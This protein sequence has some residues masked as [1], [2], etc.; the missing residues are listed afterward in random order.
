MVRHTCEAEN[1]PVVAHDDA[2]AVA[3]LHAHAHEATGEG[4]DVLVHL[5]ECPCEVSLDAKV[6]VPARRAAVRPGLL[7]AAYEAG[8]VSVLGQNGLG[9]V[10]GEGEVGEGRVRRAFDVGPGEPRGR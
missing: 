3:L 5:S 4:E 9:E 2:H 7:G 8:A 6:G 10:G 1:A